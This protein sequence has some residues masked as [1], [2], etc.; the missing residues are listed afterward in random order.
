M[1]KET[2]GK[3]S[4]Q[5]TLTEIAMSLFKILIINYLKQKL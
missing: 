5:Y 1:I 3:E 4:T 2:N